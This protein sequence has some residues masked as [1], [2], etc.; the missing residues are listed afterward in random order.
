M[1]FAALLMSSVFSS[2][3]HQTLAFDLAVIISFSLALFCIV[4]YINRNFDSSFDEIM[5]F[6]IFDK[7]LWR[8]IWRGLL[9]NQ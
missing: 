5:C 7:I 1:M 8:Q 3:V 6:V 9:R 4:R 2:S